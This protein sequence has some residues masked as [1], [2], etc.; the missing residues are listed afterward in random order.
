VLVAGE[1][2]LR[3]RV[4]DCVSEDEVE[5]ESEEGGGGIRRVYW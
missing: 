2:W 5:G 1:V 4:V 3:E